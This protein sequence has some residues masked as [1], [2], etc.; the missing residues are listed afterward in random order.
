LECEGWQPGI[1]KEIL[2]MKPT[3]VIVANEPRLLRGMLRR[4]LAQVPGLQV[5]DEI[6]DPTELLT[7]LRETK[8]EWVIV[9]LWPNGALPPVLEVLLSEYPLICLFGVAADG[10]QARVKCP[11]H[12]EQTVSG[13]SLDDLVAIL[14]S[15]AAQLEARLDVS[16]KMGSHSV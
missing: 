12:P 1:F 2:A 9:S 3:R 7:R 5:V 16:S 11:G 14:C 10:S 4:A 8:A 13:L 6:A 15:R